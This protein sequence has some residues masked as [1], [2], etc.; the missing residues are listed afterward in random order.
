MA[1]TIL[2]FVRD[3]S[4]NPNQLKATLTA[5]PKLT[6][7]KRVIDM[8]MNVATSLLNEIKSRELDN[9]FAAE[10]NISKQAS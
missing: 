9:F 5:M 7:K 3:G 10:D 4:L 2:K 6:E 8:H 1:F